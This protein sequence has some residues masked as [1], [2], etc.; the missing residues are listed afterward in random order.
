MEFLEPILR[1]TIEHLQVVTNTIE[2]EIVDFDLGFGE[3]IIVLACQS[4][5]VTAAPTPS[6]G[7]VG[8]IARPD[9][10]AAVWQDMVRNPDAI[11]LRKMSY[12]L[13]TNG[14]TTHDEI[15]PPVSIPGG[16]YI[17]TRLMTAMFGTV[18]AARQWLYI[19]YKRVR[20]DDS[21]LVALVSLRR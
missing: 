12:N 5:L 3:G 11:Y 13:S 21:E 6:S 7:V 16:G 10:V 1:R 19:W 14:A 9:A 18:A 4:A 15:D 2:E 8:L 20:L 17:H